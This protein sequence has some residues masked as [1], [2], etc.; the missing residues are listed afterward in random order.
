MVS[1]DEFERLEH[2]AEGAALYAQLLELT[3]DQKARVAV[4][5]VRPWA[6][7]NGHRELVEEIDND[8]VILDWMRRG[9]P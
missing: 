4:E 1:M 8:P 9:G 6:E 3:P 7:R 5:V 2:E